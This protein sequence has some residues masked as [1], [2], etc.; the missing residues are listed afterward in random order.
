DEAGLSATLAAPFAT[1]GIAS[2]GRVVAGVRYLPV[3]TPAVTPRDRIAERAVRELERW[4]DDP[5]FRFT[6]PLAPAATAFRQRV[7]EAIAAI[8]VGESRTYAEVARTVRS[9]ARA[10]GGACGAN[11][12]AL[13]VPCHRVVGSRGALGGFMHGTQ[14]DAIAIKRWLLVHE[15][16]RFGR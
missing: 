14:D 9:A 8:P 7:R 16:Y 13:I 10:V 1:L 5:Q 15:G 2:D 11:T 3:R 6:V 12:I 4:L